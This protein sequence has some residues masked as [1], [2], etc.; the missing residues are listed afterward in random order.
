MKT[1]MPGHRY[2]LENFEDKNQPGQIIQFIEKMPVTE[3]SPELRTVK[4]GTT[5]EEVLKVLIDRMNSLQ[6]KFPC[7][8][9]AIVITHLETGL[10]WLE[11][12][13][14]DRMARGVEGKQVK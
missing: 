13:T 4:D 12:R 5:N 8:E 3:G 14:A 11:K 10:L 2:E 1:L 7:R 6:A 9:N